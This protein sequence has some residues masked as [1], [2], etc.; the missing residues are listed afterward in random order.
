MEQ[1]LPEVLALVLADDVFHDDVSGKLFILG[2]RSVM[3]ANVFPWNVT[4]LAAYVALVDGRGETSFRL[5]LVDADEDREPVFENESLVTFP[6][7]L[8]EIE[9]VFKLSNLVFPEPGEYRLQLYAT[10]QFLRERRVVIV[11]LEDAG[12]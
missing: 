3:G 1:P 6:D 12:R 7:P 4:R 2:I 11:P 5:R 9:L 8:T 10:G